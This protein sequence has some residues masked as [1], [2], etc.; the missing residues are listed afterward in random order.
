MTPNPLFWLGIGIALGGLGCLVLPRLLAR[1]ERAIALH[2]T[3]E[4]EAEAE[5]PPD[6]ETPAG[7]IRFTAPMTEAEAERIRK[8]FLRGGPIGSTGIFLPELSREWIRRPLHPELFDGPPRPPFDD[9]RTLEPPER[10]PG[11]TN[12]KGS[13]E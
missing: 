5:L 3:L 13:T 12:P 7:V 11:D 2:D 1:I 6:I 4:A 10:G 8:T 9:Q